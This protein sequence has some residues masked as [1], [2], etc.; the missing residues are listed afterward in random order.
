MTT[1]RG[2]MPGRRANRRR[3]ASWS[4]WPA[5]RSRSTHPA[6]RTSIGGLRRPL[7]QRSRPRPGSSSPDHEAIERLQATYP[8]AADDAT[9]RRARGWAV[10][11]ALGIATAGHPGGKPTRGPPGLASHNISPHQ[12][13]SDLSPRHGGGEPKE[14]AASMAPPALPIVS[15]ERTELR[16][17]S[18]EG[19][20]PQDFAW[21]PQEWVLEIGRA[22]ARPSGPWASGIRPGPGTVAV[23]AVVRRYG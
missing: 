2:A 16:R 22:V 21:V 18:V 5:S 17:R 13:R 4:P 10:W 6:A 9:W 11:R 7:R 8:P 12:S 1:Q 15:S 3:S 23:A 20:R 19:E 14:R